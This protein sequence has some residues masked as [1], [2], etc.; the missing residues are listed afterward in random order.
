MPSDSN[1]EIQQNL[2]VTVKIKL[3]TVPGSAIVASVTI[4]FKTLQVI[5]IGCETF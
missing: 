2:E 4:R 1:Y 5:L 3:E